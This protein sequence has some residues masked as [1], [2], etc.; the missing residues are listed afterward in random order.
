MPGCDAKRRAS[1]ML[2]YNFCVGLCQEIFGIRPWKLEVTCTVARG[3]GRTT[4][5]GGSSLP[6]AILLFF[7]VLILALVV[8]AVFVFVVIAVLIFVMMIS[9]IIIGDAA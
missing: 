8:I 5:H 7:V 4:V 2:F 6:T 3:L 1:P 9:I